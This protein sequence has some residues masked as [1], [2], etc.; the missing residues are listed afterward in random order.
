MLNII[1]ILSAASLLLSYLSPYVDPNSIS[2]ISIF[3]LAY[4]VIVLVFLGCTL[5]QIFSRKRWAI[6]MAVLFICGLHLHLRTFNFGSGDTKPIGTESLK[7]MSYNV[8]LFNLYNSDHDIELAHETRLKIL[9]FLK[10]ESPDVVCFQ[11]FYHQD[12]PTDFV[13]KDTIVPL[14]GYKDYQERYAHR[15]YGRRYIGIA[16]FS[17]YPI[18]EKGEVRFSNNLE[19]FNFAIYSDVVFGDDTL[20]I[21]NVHLQS[22][23]LSRKDKAALASDDSGFVGAIRKVI[24]AFPERAKQAQRLIEHINNSP[25]PVVLCGDFNDT[26]LSYTYQRF[27]NKLTDAWRNCSFGIGKTYAGKIPAGRIDYIF[28]SEELGSTNFK[29]QKEALSDHY[30]ISCEVFVK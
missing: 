8:R 7:I 1:S 13:T 6:T 11:E 24:G 10:K 20:R 12:R 18:I 17:K 9:S 23:K 14:L 16:L 4:P 28:H 30:A 5:L 21:Y 15:S 25:Y 19:T 29:I 2:L 22:I 27:H 3:G 26:P